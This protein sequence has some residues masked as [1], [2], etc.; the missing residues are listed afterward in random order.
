MQTL[1]QGEAGTSFTCNRGVVQQELL[2]GK[3]AGNRVGKIDFRVP[4][5]HEV[6][7]EQAAEEGCM[8]EMKHIAI[9]AAIAAGDRHLDHVAA[10]RPSSDELSIHTHN[11]VKRTS[12]KV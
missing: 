12:N 10:Q 8:V 1:Q 4:Y 2:P 6:E 3:A 11:M 5:P 9:L 7:C